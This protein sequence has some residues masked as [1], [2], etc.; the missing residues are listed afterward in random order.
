MKKKIIGLLTIVLL[1]NQ[2]TAKAQ[3]ALKGD[4]IG[5]NPHKYSVEDKLTIQKKSAE[6]EK[7]FK[8]KTSKL[9]NKSNNTNIGNYVVQ[10]P[11]DTD[12]GKV[13]R[14]G[15]YTQ[16]KSYTCGPTAARNLI[17]GYVLYNGGYTPAESTLERDLGT[18]TDGT[19][20][21]A[22]KWQT[23]L[24]N[25]APGNSYVLQWATSSWLT[26]LT[27]KVMYTIDKSSN[28]N[29]IANINHGYTTTPIH[30]AYSNGAAHYV[31]VYGYDNY[32]NIYYI[33]DSNGVTG[34]TY[35]TSYSRLA[36][37]TQARGI[38]W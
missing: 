25:Y 17:N 7:Y 28:Y 2:M 4:G 16:S 1:C 19:N 11:Y 33:S 34:V 3:P 14:V 13:N 38:V 9:K 12:Y 23:T 36:N 27:I 8:E 29:V 6:A 5:V 26:D 37:S 30:S 22:G 18:T 20:F 32:Q 24:N 15:Q 21:D 10:P 31:T 35:T